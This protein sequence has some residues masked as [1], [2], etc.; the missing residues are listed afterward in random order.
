[1]EMGKSFD[2]GGEFN[3]NTLA[4]GLGIVANSALSGINFGKGTLDII[5]SQ[6][7]NKQA[8]NQESQLYSQSVYSQ[9]MD[10]RPQ[11]YIYNRNALAENGKQIREI[12]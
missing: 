1:M 8:Q 5:G 6:L 9:A 7:Q 10:T 12:S 4:Q 3:P 11:D 2:N